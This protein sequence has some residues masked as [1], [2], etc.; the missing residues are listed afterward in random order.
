MGHIKLPVAVH[1]LIIKDGAILLQRRFNTGYED[2][3]YGVVAGH[4]NGGEQIMDAMLREAKEEAGITLNPDCLHIVQVMHRKKPEEERIDYFLDCSAW[5]GSIKNM[6]PNKCDDL[7]W[8]PLENLP[9][10][11]IPYV[12]Y[13]IHY[14]LRGEKFTSFGWDDN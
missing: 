2:G 8:F 1:L 4:I 3:K 12:L 6:E 9:D 14:Y 13:A 5:S 7:S 10:N 11:M